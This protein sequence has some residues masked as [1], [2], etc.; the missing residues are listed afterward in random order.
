[1]GEAL[2]KGLCALET[3]F[4]FRGVPNLD[5]AY[6]YVNVSEEKQVFCRAIVPLVQRFLK[7]VLK[8]FPA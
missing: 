8:V 7:Q 5:F 4:P 1:M 6:L 3:I 2:A